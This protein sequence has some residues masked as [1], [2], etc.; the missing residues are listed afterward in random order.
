MTNKFKTKYIDTINGK[1]HVHVEGT[2]LGSN[3]KVNVNF[4]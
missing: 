2:G 1:K 4:R 3:G